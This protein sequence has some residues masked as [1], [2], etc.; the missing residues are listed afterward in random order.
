[1]PVS[2]DIVEKLLWEILQ[3]LLEIILKLY[4]LS[5]IKP[6]ITLIFDLNILVTVH[7]KMFFFF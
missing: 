5:L 4:F 6:K 2:R 3:C 7:L 1:M